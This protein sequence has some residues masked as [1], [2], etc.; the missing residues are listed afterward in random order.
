[1]H[2]RN[3]RV[4]RAI[5]LLTGFVSEVRER[6]RCRAPL[7]NRPQQRSIDFVRTRTCRI[8]LGRRRA[9]ESLT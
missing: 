4:R 5:L 2:R 1:V 7:R 6:A 8:E 9:L 3:P